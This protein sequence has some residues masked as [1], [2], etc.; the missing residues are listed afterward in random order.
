MIYFIRETR[1][2]VEVDFFQW[3]SNTSFYITEMYIN[4]E[5]LVSKTIS[6]SD[7]RLIKT[8]IL[9]FKSVD[10]AIEFG[11]DLVLNHARSQKVKY[12]AEHGITVLRY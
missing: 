10:D 3:D 2:S 11:K 5:K 7:D 8:I 1:P 6:Y 9:E 4:T 12:E